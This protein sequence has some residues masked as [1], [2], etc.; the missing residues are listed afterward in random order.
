MPMSVSE[1][2]ACSLPHPILWSCFA[3][4]LC[5]RNLL[6]NHVCVGQVYGV[7][8]MSIPPFILTIATTTTTTKSHQHHNMSS[9]GIMTPHFMSPNL[10]LSSLSDGKYLSASK[11]YSV[12]DTGFDRC[13]DLEHCSTQTLILGIRMSQTLDNTSFKSLFRVRRKYKDMNPDRSEVFHT[14]S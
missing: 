5:S 1:S 4:A 11:P 8:S 12:A 10:S 6:R 14:G 13:R 9:F 3:L 7:R 2:T